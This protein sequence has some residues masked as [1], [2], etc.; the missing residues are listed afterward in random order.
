M[1]IQSNPF[2][3]VELTGVCATKFRNQVAHGCPK[4]AARATVARGV[5]MSKTLKEMGSVPAKL[6]VRHLGA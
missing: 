5:G 1:G 2:G 3:R 4:P 6:K